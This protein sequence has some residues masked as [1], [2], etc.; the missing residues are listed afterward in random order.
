MMPTDNSV[1]TSPGVAPGGPPAGSTLP[2]L[3]DEQLKALPYDRLQ[4]VHPKVQEIETRY[5]AAH[6]EIDG[7]K[8]KKE[9]EAEVA[10]LKVLAGE[11]ATPVQSA[12]APNPQ[13]FDAAKIQ[14]DIEWN[15]A[16]KHLILAGGQLYAD[17][18]A[19]GMDKQDALDLALARRPS[20]EVTFAEQMRS[21]I[22]ASSGSGTDRTSNNAPNLPGVNKQYVEEMRKKFPKLSDEKLVEMVNRAQQMKERHGM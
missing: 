1:Q 7:K 20:G 15:I 13:A 8:T 17:N 5:A 14:S 11:E 18:L 9:L 21:Q 2:E 6:K 10:R 22:S 4:K 3:T 16:N 19:K 12:A